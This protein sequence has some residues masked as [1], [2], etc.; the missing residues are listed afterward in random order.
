MQYYELLCNLVEA[1][2]VRKP[3]KD[4]RMI[5]MLDDLYE[6]KGYETLKR[7]T[8]DRSTWRKRVKNLLYSR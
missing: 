4:R 5:E 3:T 1:R 2:M 7:T 6:N 8:E